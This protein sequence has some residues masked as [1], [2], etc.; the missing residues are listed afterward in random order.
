LGPASETGVNIHMRAD[1]GVATVTGAEGV[2]PF[3]SASPLV[4]IH[5]TLYAHSTGSPVRYKGLLLALTLTIASL[6][7]FPQE[8]GVRKEGVCLF[9]GN[10]LFAPLPASP[11]EPRVGLRREFGS[12][13][14]RLDIGAS[15]DIL[16]YN[17]ASDT[18][19]HFRV[20]ADLF[21]YALTTSYQ[22][23]HLQVD[24]VD[25]YFGGHV[26]YLHQ[27][28]AS[29]T[30][31]RL[32]ILHLSSHLI[33][34]HFRLETKTWLDGQ[35]PRPYS[36]DYAEATAA[37]SWGGARWS[38]VLY[39]GFLHAWFVRPDNMTRFNTFQGVL[40]RTS[41]WIGPLWGTPV[42]LYVADHFMLS[43]VD[44]LSGSNTLEGGVKFGEWSG[45]G[46]KL[47][48]SYHTGMEIYHQYYDVKRSDVGIGFALDVW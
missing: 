14:M 15:Y 26:I 21:A 6:R 9:P 16:G 40:A 20:G 17:P 41:Q 3:D 11:E 24:A 34:G 31:L 25:G 1:R 43:G 39:A 33:D 30:L 45:G 2:H 29:F 18:S 8:Q 4:Y 38:A 46:M 44:K 10:A 23:L 35:L 42:N 22:G 5:T 48:V 12:M 19:A 36:R 13:R 7:A 27:R 28:P 37:Y 32:R 47:Y